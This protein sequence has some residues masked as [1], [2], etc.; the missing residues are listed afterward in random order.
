MKDLNLDIGLYRD[1]GLAASYLTNRQTEI[2]KDNGLN[3]SIDCNKIVVNFL[4]V[5]LDLRSN[6]YKPYIKP[7]ENIQYVNTSSD[8]PPHVIRNIPLGVNTRL[9]ML[10]CN[11]DIFNEAAPRYQDALKKSGYSYILKYSPIDSNNV[12]SNHNRRS[13]NI[14]WFNPPYSRMVKTNIGKEFF[15][16]LDECFPQTNPLS[17]IFNRNKVKLSYSCCSNFRSRISR[18]NKIV[19]VKQKREQEQQ[20]MCNCQQKTSCPLDGHCQRSEVVY[21]AE[22]KRHDGGDAQYYTGCTRNYFKIRW[23]KH[24]RSFNNEEYHKE[25]SLSA[26]VW[27]LKRQNIGYDIKWK[28]LARAKSYSPVSQICNLCNMEKLYIMYHPEG[29]TLNKRTEAFNFCLHKP[30]KSLAAQKLD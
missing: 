17:K 27:D 23:A 15:K 19:E 22:V 9:S 7:N 12:H 21:R 14:I 13:R 28:I 8:H 5:T 30:W 26:Y 4:D 25:T 18:N 2:F 16:I 10:S 1:D 11:E 3:I 29:A 6:I 20:A 24:K